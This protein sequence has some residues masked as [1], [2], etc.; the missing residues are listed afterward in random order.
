MRAQ[1]TERKTVARGA[2]ARL[3]FAAATLMSFAAGACFAQP[4]GA[5]AAANTAGLSDK[6]RPAAG[7]SLGPRSANPQALLAR[8]R[9]AGIP[10]NEIREQSINLFVE[11]TRPRFMPHSSVDLRH[12][13]SISGKQFNPAGA[14]LRPRPDWLA[15]YVGTMEPLIHLFKVDMEEAGQA[16]N[17]SGLSPAVAGK[18][19]PLKRQWHADVADLDSHLTGLFNL[20][21]TAPE[22]DNGAVAREAAAMFEITRRMEKARHRAF[23]IVLEGYKRTG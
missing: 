11:A 19:A 7:L 6:D 23:K 1:G 5:P 15:F 16:D 8:I 9:D 17:Q 18:L 12:P 2:D 20:L 21:A 4:P 13:S 3:I 14:Y 22:I 10:L